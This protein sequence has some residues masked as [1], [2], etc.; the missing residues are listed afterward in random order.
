MFNP[1]I[2]FNDKGPHLVK[3]AHSTECSDYSEENSKWQ[4]KVL[5][6][7]IIKLRNIELGTAWSLLGSSQAVYLT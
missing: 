2:H 4:N 5:W 7:M 1:T 6:I 3:T